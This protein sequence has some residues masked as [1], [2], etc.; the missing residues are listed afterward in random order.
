MNTEENP[1]ASHEQDSLREISDIG[2]KYNRAL[3]KIGVHRF[4]D[5]AQYTPAQLAAQLT[6][7]GDVNV[8][9]ERIEK[10]DWIGQAKRLANLPKKANAALPLVV[11]GKRPSP[12]DTKP[13]GWRQ[14]AGFSLFFD[15]I[16][17]DSG[18][19][20]WQTRLYHEE[21]Y[22]DTLLA[23][24]ETAVWADW[25]V[26][27]AQLPKV[28]SERDVEE[29]AVSTPATT[30]PDVK[31]HIDNVAVSGAAGDRIDVNI[32]LGFIGAD[33]PATSNQPI[34]C[35]VEFQTI[36]LISH[37]VAQHFE[38]EQSQLQ[39]GTG[40]FHLQKSLPIPDAGRYELFT[41][42]Y[43]QSPLEMLAC[44]T[45]PTLKVD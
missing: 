42:V 17:H 25:I 26:T 41:V 43:V 7:R 38:A 37:T 24:I 45:G 14:V 28:E 23:S 31:L 13:E 12:T 10:H 20:E 33:A 36:D 4:A 8:K 27:H 19:Q 29:T 2:P 35:L 1:L 3:K 32:R 16:V 18:E 39:P 30:L 5:L 21:T 22:Q 34:S 40:V 11:H 9:A 44:H 15:T 6:E